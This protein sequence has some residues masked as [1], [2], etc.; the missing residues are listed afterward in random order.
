MRKCVASILV[1][2]LSLLPAVTSLAWN[3]AGH[4]LVDLIAY[5][6]LTPTAKEAVNKLLK[7]H[8][9]YEKDLLAGK[10]DEADANL[11]AFLIAGTWPDIVRGQ[12]HPMTHLENHPVWHYVDYPYNLGT[13]NGPT[14]E[15]Q[16]TPGT[17]PKNALQA[18]AKIHADLTDATVKDSDKSIRLC[19][20]E[21]LTGDLHQ[22]LHAAAMYTDRFPK[23][24]RGGN[25]QIVQPHEGQPVNLHYF[26][27]SAATKDA[28]LPALMKLA[29]E[30]T[31]DPTLSREAM[32]DQLTHDAVKDWVMESYALAKSMVYRD[33]ALLSAVAPATRSAIPADVPP[34]PEGYEAAA[35]KT[36]RRQ[37]VL[38]GYRLAD[39]INALFK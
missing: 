8:P 3:A 7:Q 18:M 19:W 11:W 37:A 1:L 13:A 25:S 28:S 35:A 9:R 33:G 5:Q 20:L 38:A 2:T 22:P 32:K 21:H 29:A 36:A 6:Q 10:P 39:Q 26:W 34:L 16:W 24:D 15:E 27:D 14:P 30:L 17:D 23:G 12:A 4:E 31:A